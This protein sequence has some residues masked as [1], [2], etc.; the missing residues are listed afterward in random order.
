MHGSSLMLMAKG[1]AEPTSGPAWALGW[2]DQIF[3][4]VFFRC[5][6]I[7]KREAD[8]F[9]M[10]C[11]LSTRC[12]IRT[13]RTFCRSLV[14][15]TRTNRW[16]LEGLSV[17]SRTH[18]RPSV[19]SDARDSTWGQANQSGSSTGTAQSGMPYSTGTCRTF[20]L[21]C[22]ALTQTH[23]S[24]ESWNFCSPQKDES[25]IFTFCT[26]FFTDRCCSSWDEEDKS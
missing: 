25:H 17:T 5:D 22:N 11:R 8:C 7:M 2:P 18:S 15:R 21:R 13:S 6:K 20:F 16:Y 26:S 1:A 23:T 14:R 4:Y 3:R 19:S 24:V 9:C 12:W 10:V